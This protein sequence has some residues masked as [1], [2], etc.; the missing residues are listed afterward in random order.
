MKVPNPINIKIDVGIDRR[1]MITIITVVIVVPVVF[2]LTLFIIANMPD[3]KVN[4]I[5]RVIKAVKD[6]DNAR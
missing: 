6:N 5:E 3:R 1:T 2:F 4:K